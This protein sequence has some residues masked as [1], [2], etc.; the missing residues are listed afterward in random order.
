MSKLPAEFPRYGSNCT[1]GKSIPQEKGINE[2]LAMLLHGSLGWGSSLNPATGSVIVRT[3]HKLVQRA[4]R[5][6]S[7]TRAQRVLVW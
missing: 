7:Q 1:Q 5:A 6:S 2:E 4:G 3:G